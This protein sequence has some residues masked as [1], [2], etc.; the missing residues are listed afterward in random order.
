M[1]NPQLDSQLCCLPTELLFNIA[2]Y[3]F[4]GFELDYF[5][6]RRI[7]KPPE[8]EADFFSLLQTCHKL[9]KILLPIL[10][11]CTT[12]LVVKV[13]IDDHFVKN[14]PR[15][16]IGARNINLSPSFRAGIRHLWL[17]PGNR[18]YPDYT[19]FPNLECIHMGL[20][21]RLNFDLRPLNQSPSD[22]W[23]LNVVM[24]QIAGQRPYSD[25]FPGLLDYHRA[26]SEAD[27]EFNR[28]T[29]QSSQ[30]EQRKKSKIRLIVH[31]EIAIRTVSL[32]RVP[33]WIRIPVSLLPLVASN[34][35]A[36]S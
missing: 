1:A 36:S 26:L 2:S 20:R 25:S 3:V 22:V 16:Q 35:H 12:D 18:R 29:I 33:S 5:K 31:Q 24:G 23:L 9:R 34:A 7:Q 21:P 27:K 32:R 17:V 6:A 15:S 13:P 30:D 4:A 11:A 19:L 10:G 8:F 14:P 28:R